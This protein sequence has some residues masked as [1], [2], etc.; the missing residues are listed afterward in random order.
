MN[1]LVTGAGGF[2]G[3]GIA[4]A[5]IARGHVVHAIQRGSY[6]ALDALAREGKAKVFRGDLVDRDG[7]LRAAEGCGAAFH[8]AAKAGVWGPYVDYYRSNV[9]ATEHVLAACRAHGIGRLI[10]TSTP[11]VVHAGHDVTGV[12][13]RAPYA[14]KYETAYP[15]TKAIA[16]RMVLAA[17]GPG[18]ATIA[19][20]PHLV[21]GPGDPHLVPRLI[22]RARKGRLMLVGGGKNRIDATYIDSAVHAHLC[23]FDRLAPGAPVLGKPC[24][25]RA[26]FIAQGE[27]MPLAELV[28]GIL[29]AAGVAPVTRSISPRRA[30][31]AGAVLEGAFRLAGAKSEPPLTRFVA[32]QLATE[33]FFDLTAAKRDL[34]YQAPVTTAEGLERLRLSLRR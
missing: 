34:G 12:D 7:V 15:E 31:L 27:P 11:S 21:W 16:E 1:V 18:L 4:R 30:W 19:L 26:Y 23:A 6:P 10:H 3:G 13:E 29:G 14:E 17:N 5:L 28:N 24:A 8:V 25:G 32:R 22:D 2:V 20:R 33:H 9:V